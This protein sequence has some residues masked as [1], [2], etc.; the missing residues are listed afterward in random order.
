MKSPIV[1]DQ[2]TLRVAP[3][4]NPDNVHVMVPAVYTPPSEIDATFTTR[5]AGTVSTTV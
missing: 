5:P 3:T 2:V 4:V 1:A